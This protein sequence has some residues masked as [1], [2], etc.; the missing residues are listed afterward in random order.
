MSNAGNHLG[1][2]SGAFELS[3]EALYEGLDPLLLQRKGRL[4]LLATKEADR[5]ALARLCREFYE[6]RSYDPIPTLVHILSQAYRD[7]PTLA[8]QCPLAVVL[9]GLELNMVGT[10]QAVVRLMRYGVVRDLFNAQASQRGFRVAMNR[11]DVS[12][13]IPPIYSAQWRLVSGDM[14]MFTVQS[15]A[16]RVGA[17][18]IRRVV[19]LSGSASRAATL[20]GRLP[21][22]PGSVPIII[23]QQGQFSPVPEMSSSKP[24][25][26][27]EQESQRRRKRG[28]SPIWAALLVTL[29]AVVVTLWTT[30]A[31]LDT[32][33]LQDYLL[34]MFFPPSTPTPTLEVDAPEEEIIIVVDLPYDPPTLVSPYTGARL[35]GEEIT[36]FWEWEG[37]LAVSELYEVIL[38]PAGNDPEARTVTGAQRHSVSIGED[39]WYRWSVRI[40]DGTDRQNL[41]P[42]SP[43][44]EAISFLWRAE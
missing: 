39:G 5:D 27:A 34:M 23:M 16:A 22:V 1:Y 30:G 13:R 8:E 12:P 32:D 38:W 26:E 31:H 15:V 21:R 6:S 7:Q 25:P 19:R 40:V 24:P 44:A 18:G 11:R 43:E 41:V 42:L 35:E 33:E 28:W 37:E 14:L 17:G 2:S 29:L 3:A 20:I 10:D 36:L 4:I 9:R